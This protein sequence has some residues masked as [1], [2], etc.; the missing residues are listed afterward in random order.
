M[1]GEKIADHRRAC[2]CREL[3]SGRVRDPV[4]RSVRDQIAVQ[5]IE[6]RVVHHEKVCGCIEIRRSLPL[7]QLAR[8]EVANYR[9]CGLKPHAPELM[10]KAIEEGPPEEAVMGESIVGEDIPVEPAVPIR[11]DK[12]FVP[13]RELTQS[14]CSDNHSG[15]PTASCIV[16]NHKN[17]RRDRQ[18]CANSANCSTIILCLGSSEL[19]VNPCDALHLFNY[20][21][22]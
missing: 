8:N 6:R 1:H 19:H 15:N 5:T 16:L 13:S 22:R 20:S 3:A 17:R 14:V 2:I 10:H 18:S 11:L 4:K 7:K 21:I 9:R 12:P